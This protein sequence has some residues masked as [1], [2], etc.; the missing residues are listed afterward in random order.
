M[1]VILILASNFV[2]SQAVTECISYLVS[3]DLQNNW[4]QFYLDTF[5]FYS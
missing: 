2:F 5:K 1:Q 4:F 3:V